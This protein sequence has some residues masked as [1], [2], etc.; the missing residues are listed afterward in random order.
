MAGYELSEAGDGPP[1]WHPDSKHCAGY[2]RPRSRLDSKE[3]TL[4]DDGHDKVDSTLGAVAERY[5]VTVEEHHSSFWDALATA[6]IFQQMI[7]QVQR[8]GILHLRDLL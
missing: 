5:H 3:V 6:Q 1:L 2:G 7:K 8:L 4:V